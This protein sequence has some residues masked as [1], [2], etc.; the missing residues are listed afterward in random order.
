M[1]DLQLWDYV[2]A[3]GLVVGL[4][5]YWDLRDYKRWAKTVRNGTEAMELVRSLA[6]KPLLFGRTGPA[7]RLEDFAEGDKS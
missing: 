6:G 7:K 2:M 1:F 4:L 5:Q 3:A